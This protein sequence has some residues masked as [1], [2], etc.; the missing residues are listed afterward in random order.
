VDAPPSS[1]LRAAAAAAAAAGG[2]PAGG[3]ALPA[4]AA[5][6]AAP[7]AADAAPAPPLPLIAAGRKVEAIRVRYE[8]VAKKVDVG[9]LKE[10]LGAVLAGAVSSGAM[11]RVAHG[12]GEAA[13]REGAAARAETWVDASGAGG[14][15]GEGAREA[16]AGRATAAARAPQHI[17]LT[18]VI[19]G[20]APTLS[21]QVTV[22]FYFITL[23]HIANE[24]GLAIADVEGLKDLHIRSLE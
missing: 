9:A 5:A 24:Q 16:R 2:T 1:P 12:V 15:C 3:G 20:L 4:P 8:T 11:G 21:A 6:P 23:L 14:G 19:K 18:Q 17:A 10:D 22:P 7:P 13:M